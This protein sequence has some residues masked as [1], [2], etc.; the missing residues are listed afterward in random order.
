MARVTRVGSDGNPMKKGGLG[1]PRGT[2]IAPQKIVLLR[3]LSCHVIDNKAHGSFGGVNIGPKLRGF[4]ACWHQ[5][6]VVRPLLQS[7]SS[8]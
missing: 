3:P 5:K 2:R 1:V 7:P 4:Q 8:P 6:L